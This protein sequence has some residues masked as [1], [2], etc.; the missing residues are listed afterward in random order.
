M[1]SFNAGER[2]VT[3][4]KKSGPCGGSGGLAS[5]GRSVFSPWQEVTPSTRIMLSSVSSARTGRQERGDEKGVTIRVLGQGNQ[6]LPA[7]RHQQGCPKTIRQAP[8]GLPHA[9]GALRHDQKL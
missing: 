7:C 4:S 1:N 5:V 2:F 3:S 8:Q 6:W 9:A